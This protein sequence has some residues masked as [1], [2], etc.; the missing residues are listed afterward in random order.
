MPW[1]DIPVDRLGLP[2]RDM[3]R[4]NRAGIKTIGELARQP[5]T[6]WQEAD[7]ILSQLHRCILWLREQYSDA[8]LDEVDDRG[9]SALLRLDLTSAPLRGILDQWMSGLTPRQ[10]KVAEWRFGLSGS[11]FT[12]QEAAQQL[13]LTRERVRQIENRAITRLKHP[14]RS[15]IVWP[16]ACLLRDVARRAGGLVTEALW[17]DSLAAL[18]YLG[19]IDPFGVARLLAATESGVFERSTQT[20]VALLGA[21]VDLIP[22]ITKQLVSILAAELAP[23]RAEE[24]LERFK[25]TSWFQDRGERLPDGFV[26]SCLHLSAAIV[27]CGGG[28]YRLA[29]RDRHYHDDIVRAL[30]SLGQPAHYSVIADVVNERL[31]PERQI[32]ARGVHARLMRNSGLFVRANRPGAYGLREWTPEQLAIRPGATAKGH[33]TG[34]KSFIDRWSDAAVSESGSPQSS[35]PTAIDAWLARLDGRSAT[36]VRRYYG[37]GCDAQSVQSLADDTGLSPMRVYQILNHARRRLVRTQ[38]AAVRAALKDMHHF[39]SER[40]GVV[41]GAEIRAQLPDVVPLN[42]LEPLAA[43]ELLTQLDDGLQWQ[44]GDELLICGPYNQQLAKD[45]RTDLRDAIRNRPAGSTVDDIVY[46]VDTRWRL[47]EIE[48]P[49]TERFIRACLRTH[50]DVI[51]D[52]NL[53]R[54]GKSKAG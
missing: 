32:S 44:Q 2:Q 5:R 18:T 19:D 48:I 28:V 39:V 52:G 24:I 45:I 42:G 11:R 13:G 22:Q 49:V 15:H 20:F 4:L 54:L 17:R 30:R 46:D 8:W 35:L 38:E 10:R 31:S 40:G 7:R 14:S 41:N 23:L 12:L 16:L 33:R 1:F 25:A 21:P 36:I 50:P 3:D 43:V 51:M 9:M 37:L 29:K 27:A 26:L 34:G 6:S 47:K 53:A